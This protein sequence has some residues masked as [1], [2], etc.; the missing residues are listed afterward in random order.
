MKIINLTQV[1]NFN[2]FLKGTIM[3]EEKITNVTKRFVV[4]CF[5][6]EKGIVWSQ[7]D[8]IEQAFDIASKAKPNRAEISVYIWD[9]Q[10]RKEYQ[11]AFAKD[12][13]GEPWKDEVVDVD[14]DKAA[15]SLI[16][17]R[18]CHC[19]KYFEEDEEGGEEITKFF[20]DFN[21]AIKFYVRH[22]KET[23]RILNAQGTQYD[24]S[25]GQYSRKLSNARRK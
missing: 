5:D 16:P 25:Q 20:K 18:F 14:G 21:N 15:F 12:Y 6:D 24:L 9:T 3:S 2:Y 22:T 17:K 4:L 7:V 23:G 11:V 10:N 13:E 19:V 8:N 1:T